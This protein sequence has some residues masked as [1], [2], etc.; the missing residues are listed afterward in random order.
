MFNLLGLEPY[1]INHTVKLL[2]L[3]VDWLSLEPLQSV[4]SQVV[5][6]KQPQI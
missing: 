5:E 3:E 2:V 4:V 1:K 6:P